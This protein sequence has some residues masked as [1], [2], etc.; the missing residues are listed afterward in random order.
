MALFGQV[1]G[2]QY[3]LVGHG[4]FLLACRLPEAA[5]PAMFGDNPS[6]KRFIRPCFGLR[7]WL[8]VTI[9]DGGGT[10]AAIMAALCAATHRMP[11]AADRMSVV[12]GKHGSVRV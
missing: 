12:A 11:G 4:V 10:Q 8:V 1:D 3:V 6:F 2:D 7:Q 9:D 5:V